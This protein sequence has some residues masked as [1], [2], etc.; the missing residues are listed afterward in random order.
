MDEKLIKFT[1]KIPPCPK[2]GS[3]KVKRHYYETTDLYKFP[4]GSKFE[5]IDEEEYP[6][7]LKLICQ[8]CWY[9]WGQEVKDV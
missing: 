5:D 1:I 3:K 4:I 8:I 9:E 2:C 6:E 7:F